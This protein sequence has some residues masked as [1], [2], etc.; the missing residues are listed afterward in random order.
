MKK[1]LTLLLLAISV[2]MF[3]QNVITGINVTIPAN[4]DANTA[5][6]GSGASVFT[7]SA[8]TTMNNI[9]LA[10][11]SKILVTIKK[12]G[13]RICGSYT[14]ATAPEANFNTTA[15]KR[16]WNGQNAV[17]LLGQ[18]CVLK[19]GDYELCVQ[20]FGA[21]MP[22]RI[23]CEE[24]C[25]PFSIKAEEEQTYQ[26]PQVISP[27]DGT[28]IGKTAAK[29]PL[30]FRWTPVVPKPKADVVYKVRII[31][32]RK[33]Q[34]G[35]SAMQAGAPIFEKEVINQ[36]QLTGISLSQLP[37]AK[38]SKYAWYVQAVN[39]EG[40]PFGGNNGTSGINAFKI[41]NNIDIQIDSLHIGCCLNGF[42]SIYLKVKNNL[43]TDVKIMTIG[44]RKNG[45]G[46]LVDITPLI[47]PPLPVNITGYGVKVFTS[48]IGCIDG[49]ESLKL[50]IYAVDPTD[51][52]N[53]ENES[54]TD[55]LSCP[56][57]DCDS[58]NLNIPEQGTFTSD[59]TLWMHTPG[60][61]SPGIIK[62]IK[63][64]LVYFEYK[65]E[66]DDCVPCNRDSKDWG[67]FISATLSDADF[68]TNAILNWGHEVQWNST[69]VTGSNL[70]GTF[71]FNISLPPLVKCCS[72]KIK[73]CIRYIF[74]FENCVICEKLVC[75]SHSITNK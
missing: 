47:I 33:G 18:D 27:A 42:Q 4:P 16:V 44:Y 69:N 62:T 41:D 13:S 60:S 11:G 37:I 23:L 70:N 39:K 63:A 49:L 64:Q 32:I 35:T 52:D 48:S 54:I 43:S 8:A 53:Y 36:N 61:A 24:V 73:F 7:I 6:W 12:G 28:V 67:N 57:T 55:T 74:E 58:I 75:Y 59:S 3:A 30:T 56:C 50:L 71:N 29:S 34:T 15:L 31:E 5:N 9:K 65:P 72:V 17:A 66:S 25:K 10:L 40:R 22:P 51:P 26:A 2:Q 14:S 20:F 19:P 45:T 21:A 38:D 46:P 68:N 1:I